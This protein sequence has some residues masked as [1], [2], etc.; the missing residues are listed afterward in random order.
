MCRKQQRKRYGEQGLRAN[1]LDILAIQQTAVGG[2]L[3]LQP[4]L[5]IQQDV[6]L[7]A[8]LLH[9]PAQL[10]QLLLQAADQTLDLG[11]LHAVSAFGLF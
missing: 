3:L 5:H 9:L 11:Q 8:L 10:S 4:S 7:L 2:D 1:S 6:V